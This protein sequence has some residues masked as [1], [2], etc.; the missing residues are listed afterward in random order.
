[1]DE[2]SCFSI[3]TVVFPAGC[4]VWA[5]PDAALSNVFSDLDFTVSEAFSAILVASL[6]DLITREREFDGNG[7]LLRCR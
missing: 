2:E 1:V 3:A 5:G 4:G 7:P 6:V